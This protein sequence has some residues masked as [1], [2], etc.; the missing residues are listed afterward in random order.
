MNVS[1]NDHAAGN[2]NRDKLGN[3][4]FDWTLARSASKEHRGVALFGDEAAAP[5]CE[6]RPLSGPRGRGES[7]G[8]IVRVVSVRIV[9]F[10]C[11]FS[12]SSPS[13]PI[14]PGL[15]RN[16]PGLSVRHL[17]QQLVGFLVPRHALLLRIPPQRTS[18]RI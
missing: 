18:Q 13:H 1:Q 14:K 15:L 9:G 10:R 2:G 4:Q 11:H 12:Q 5:D 16:R 6:Y 3:L 7:E 8:G 17:A